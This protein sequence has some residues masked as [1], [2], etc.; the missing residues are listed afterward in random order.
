MPT[1]RIFSELLDHSR[2]IEGTLLRALRRFDVELVVATQ[3]EQSAT[4]VDV[5]RACETAG[6]SLSLWPMLNDAQ[7]RWPSTAN[8]Q[9]FSKFV[10]R[11]LRLFEAS[12]ARPQRLLIDLEPPIDR[13]KQMTRGVLSKAPPEDG[14]LDA[15]RKTLADSRAAG[16]EVW[17]TV[18][19]PTVIGDPRSC[20][21]W[22]ALLGT[23]IDALGVEKIC[24]MAYTSLIEGY[25]KRTLKRADVRALLAR[26]S[27]E[28]AS[29]YGDRAAIAL[30][31]VGVGALGDEAC[32]RSPEVLADDVAIVRAA[33]IDDISLFNLRGVIERGPI[34]A[35]LSALTST[36]PIKTKTLPPMTAKARLL[37]AAQQ[38]I[39]KTSARFSRSITAHSGK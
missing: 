18:M 39:G 38:V 16:I 30:G 37:W 10:A 3:P 34:D 17:S 19:P 23:P 11:L 36:P 8:A 9:T 5:I 26:W 7:G 13:L 20:L 35:W 2:L 21:G 14:A 25:S 32:L 29:K 27:A 12:A 31:A 22:Q 28:L 15:L 33:G 24:P 6:V 1:R 4:C